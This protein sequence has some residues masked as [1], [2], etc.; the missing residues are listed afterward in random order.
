MDNSAGIEPLSYE[1]MYA[2]G[3]DMSDD[4][5]SDQDA[6]ESVD[7]SVRIQASGIY[8]LAIDLCAD[9]GKLQTQTCHIVGSG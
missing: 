6:G 2:E 5:T 3:E 8:F 9:E 1:P 7:Q 4:V